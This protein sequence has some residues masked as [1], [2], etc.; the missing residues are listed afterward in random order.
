M[1]NSYYYY[2]NEAIGAFVIENVLKELTIISL[3]KSLLLL[4]IFLHDPIVKRLSSSA[5]YRSID[6]F[7]VKERINLGDFNLRMQNLLPITINSISILKDIKTVTQEGVFLKANTM[8]VPVKKIDIGKRAERILRVI[9]KSTFLFVED[10][11]STF[12]KFNI[13][14]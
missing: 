4:P 12:L 11:A 7:L 2:D 9:P 1:E 14:L 10:D 5:K 3:A 6:E 13:E 8:K